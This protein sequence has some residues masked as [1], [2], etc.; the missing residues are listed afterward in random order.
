MIS[1][2]I[3]FQVSHVGWA[4]AALV[5]VAAGVF[6]VGR[7]RRHWPEPS[8]AGWAAPLLKLAGLFLLAAMLLNPVLTGRDYRKGAND[9]VLL[10]DG[11]QSMELHAGDQVAT[12]L[13]AMEEQPESW[14]ARLEQE[15]RLERHRFDQRLRSWPETGRPG[16]EGDRSDLVHALGQVKERFARRPLAGVLVF[17]DGLIT[18]A[19]RI[20]SLDLGFPVFPVLCQSGKPVADV[21]VQGV[22]VATTDFE[23]AP[24]TMSVQVHSENLRAGKVVT[25]V[26]DEAGTEVARDEH[27]IGSERD[28]HAFQARFRPAKPGLATYR[29][30]A[31]YQGEAADA[32]PRNNTWVESVDRGRGP[33]RV[34]YVGGR[35]N[36]E[37]KFLGRALAPDADLQLVSLVRVAKREPK[38]VWRGRPG[39]TSNP[40]FRGFQGPSPE[41]EPAH[42]KPVLIRLNT[43]SPEELRTGFPTAPGELF[44][45]YQAVV[46]DDLEADFFTE[47]QQLLLDKFVSER[48][49]SLLV[50]GGQ[51][52]FNFG[53]FR[54]TTLGQLLPV[55]LG[56][57]PA[58]LPPADARLELTREG[59]L[60]PWVRL[61]RTEAEE[62]ERLAGQPAFRSFHR[63]GDVK[64]GASI[65]ASVVD[66]SQHRYPALVT[67]AFGEGRVAALL[68]GDV[69][70]WGMEDEA[71]RA[72]ME[73]W[74]RQVFRWLVADV[75]RFVQVETS[76]DHEGLAIRTVQVRVR[77]KD[78][79]PEENATVELRVSEAGNDSAE[80]ASLIAAPSLD[81]PGLYVAKVPLMH[82]GA[83][84]VE[85]RVS[86]AG[87]ESLGQEEAGWSWNPSGA[88]FASLQAKPEPLRRIAATTGGRLLQRGDLDGFLRELPRMAMPVQETWTRP[89]WHQPAMFLLVLGCLLGEWALR[90]WRGRA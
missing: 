54:R 19:E 82:P 33:Y 86:G 41:E 3:Q 58:E 35:P 85:A 12:E 71:R 16:F 52:S 78:F 48:G 27:R 55:Y 7:S 46:L 83:Y 31:T 6:L 2:A 67:Q 70:R 89:L 74:W 72:D 61:R 36:W 88:E 53:G 73:R 22:T 69:W 40:L 64:P 29:I 79:Q 37:H 8:W 66:G 5:L 59:W 84:R 90:R 30:E 34:L 21:G 68:L 9:F 17:S 62:R 1:M 57:A 76:W 87:G 47:D 60:E 43:A 15:F 10:L 50:L 18:D 38:F 26:R 65:L 49:G 75:P 56:G 63:L 39:E 24:V 4:A 25:T 77:R 51:E 14:L 42:D 23:D 28:E 11:G 81:E 80:P 44:G 13:Q 20:D 32:T 45:R